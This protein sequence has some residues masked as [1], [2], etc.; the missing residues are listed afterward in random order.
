MRVILGID[1]GLEGGL[2]FV[3]EL[4]P[5][6]CSDMPTIGEGTGRV[7]NALRVA[8]LID[9]HD[10]TEAAIENVWSQP[11]DGGIQAFRF[12]R[13]A[14]QM[15]AVLQVCKIPFRQVA[16]QTWKRSHSLLKQGKEASRAAALARFPDLHDKLQLKKHHGRAE[17]LLIA[18]YAL[19]MPPLA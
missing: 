11:K 12:G 15:L 13:S 5:H 4:G 19:H 6:D 7:I 10:V 3:S 16:P 1:P 14:G 9:E 2:G 17:A 18:S 8:Q